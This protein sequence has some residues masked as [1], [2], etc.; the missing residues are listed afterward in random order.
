MVERWLSEP[1]SAGADLRTGQI[2]CDCDLWRGR[3]CADA[4]AR[5]NTVPEIRALAEETER[6]RNLSPRIVDKIREAKLLRTMSS[7]SS[8]AASISGRY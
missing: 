5:A 8:R 3:I 4:R 1:G 2:D 7:A 6:N